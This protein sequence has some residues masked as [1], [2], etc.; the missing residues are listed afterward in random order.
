M[1]DATITAFPSEIIEARRA[2][3]VAL[4]LGSSGREAI[5]AGQEAL[6]KIRSGVDRNEAIHST[7]RRIAQERLRMSEQDVIDQQP[8]RRFPTSDFMVI[9][10]LVAIPL[11]LVGIGY[12]LGAA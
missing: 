12:A 6:F 2:I 8:P 9:A 3:R 4:S 10:A 11:L 1:Q 7:M 5:S